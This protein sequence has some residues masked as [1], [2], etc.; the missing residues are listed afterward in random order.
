MGPA[1]IGPGQEVKIVL[2]AQDIGARIVDIEK[3][4]QIGKLV[5]APQIVDTRVRQPYSMLRGQLK[6]K[7]GLERALDMHV[8]L[9]LRQSSNELRQC[10]FHG[11]SGC[12]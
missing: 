3:G 2:V 4:L 11:E 8:E 9:R 1:E 7:L 12:T 10:R 5:G 6:G